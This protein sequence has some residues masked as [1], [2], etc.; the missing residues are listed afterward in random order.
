MPIEVILPTPTGND[1]GRNEPYVIDVRANEEVQNLAVGL[2]FA[3]IVPTE[4]AFFGDPDSDSDFELAY[5]FGSTIEAVSDASPGWSRWRFTLFRRP[6]WLGN[7][8]AT[9]HAVIGVVGPEGPPGP[10]GPQGEQ[11]PP[12]TDG[13]NGTNGS[14]GAAG[15]P[16]APGAPGSQGL[17]GAAG[18]DGDDGEDGEDGQPGFIGFV[19][20]NGTIT[21]AQPQYLNIIDGDGTDAVLDGT[22]KALSFNVDVSDFAGTN[23]E[24][25]GSNNLRIAATAAGAGLIGG[26]ASA[27]AVG[28]GTGITVNA[29]DV[30]I[31]TIA[32]ESFF[33][34]GTA[35]A[36]VPTAIAGST[37][38]GAGLTYT[39]GGILAVGAGTGLTVN[40]NDVQLTTIADDTFMANVSGGAAVA[41]GKTFTS[42]GGDGIDYNA[43]THALDVAVSDFA[44][45][46]L[47][48]DGS[49]NLRIAASAA[50]AG[51]IGGGASALAVG[52]GTFITV[53]A[54]DV[55]LSPV[56]AGRVYGNQIDAVGSAIVELTGAELGENLQFGTIV[57][58]SAA[59]GTQ[60]AYSFPA[61]NNVL[62]VQ[63]TTIRFQGIV[64]RPTGT[65]LWI[66]HTGSGS[67]T[68]E[69]ESVGALSADTLSTGTDS[70]D[71]VLTNRMQALFLYQN[72]RWRLHATSPLVVNENK[73]DLTVTGTRGQTWTINTGGIALTKLAP[74]ADDT[75]LV[76]IAG[77]SASP[78]AVALTAFGGDGIDYNATT[79]AFDVAVADFAGTNLENDGSN[80]LRIAATAAGAGLTGGGASALAVGAGTAIVVNANDVAL[81]VA[82]NITWTGTHTFDDAVMFQKSQTVSPSGVTDI[83]LDADVTHLYLTPS[84]DWSL[85]E[86]GPGSE[87]RILFV[88]QFGAFTGTITSRGAGGVFCPDTVS[89]TITHRH[90]FLLR[91]RIDGWRVIAQTN[92]GVWFEVEESGAGPFNDYA[93]GA[94]TRVHIM[95][96]N[97]AGV[98]NG[99]IGATVAGR[100]L[101]VSHQGTGTTTLTHNNV[102][103][104][105][106]TRFF[107]DT[108]GASV[109]LSDNQS[110]FYIAADVTAGG[111]TTIRW[112]LVSVQPTS[113]SP[114]QMMGL[115]VDAAGVAFPVPLTG[116]EQGEN[117]RIDTRVDDASTSGT[118]SPY[119][120]ATQVNWVRFTALTGL[121]TLNGCDLTEAGKLIVW[122]IEPALA[123]AATFV[124]SNAATT[125]GHRFFCPGGVNITIGAGDIVVTLYTS[126]RH[127]VISVTRQT[128]TYTTTETT[129]GTFAPYTLP[130]LTDTLNVAATSTFHGFTGGVEGRG[131]TVSNGAAVGSGVTISFVQFSS[132]TAGGN[133]EKLILNTFTGTDSTAVTLSPGA[134][135]QLRYFGSR[136][137]TLENVS[138]STVVAVES[139]VAN[140]TAA[141]APMVP[142][143]LASLAGV[144]L[145]YN[146]TTKAIDVRQTH[147]SQTLAVDLT[148][149]NP[150]G[151]I[152][153][154]DVLNIDP[155]AAILLNSLQ[156]PAVDGKQV[157]VTKSAN[158]DSLTIV[159]Q[160]GLGVA[161]N[162]IICIGN[163][164]TPNI[165]LRHAQS[166]VLLQYRTA[167]SR[168]LV[169]EWNPGIASVDNPGLVR[170]GTSLSMSTPDLLNYSGNTANV[171]IS[172]PTGNQGTIDISALT[173]GGTVR[174]LTPV[175]D[176]QIEG[177]TAKTD[178]F[179]FVFWYNGL[180]T[181]T[182]FD[183]DVT[184]TSTNR[185]RFPS[186]V[187]L[188]ADL[189]YGILYYRDSRW[190]WLS[191]MQAPARFLTELAAAPTVA[192]AQAAV[193]AENIAPTQPRWTNDAGN[194]WPLGFAAS[195][196]MTATTTQT[197]NTTP[198][199][200]ASMTVPA[201]ELFQ[202]AVIEFVAHIR[203][204][205]GVI[206]TA[207]DINLQFRVNTTQRYG[208]SV[209]LHTTN[210]FSGHFRIV[211]SLNILAAPGASIDVSVSGQSVESITLAGSSV[212]TGNIFTLSTNASVALDLR[213]SMSAATVGVQFFTEAA[214]IRRVR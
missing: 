106:N 155:G 89:F 55:A 58:E 1:I 118:G 23:L 123:G 122:T 125:T 110:A 25:D 117:L 81:D 199:T 173:C 168:W 188:V 74:Q 4:I 103:S 7:P 135:L 120:V 70:V 101:L 192:A 190:T 206:N 203:C 139:F 80:N 161:A 150:T 93:A 83:V 24:D 62:A 164:T 17:T 52:A 195:A 157:R 205:R 33:V 98:F 160:S 113:I 46:N 109:V 8:T 31:S 159:H 60:T 198:V 22:T 41:T 30:Q 96:S 11:G 191:S 144:G 179:W 212:V 119:S 71:L 108:L 213:A 131:L 170:P 18:E 146:T 181:C 128:G 158:S 34:N 162:D 171:D 50:G 202:G 196:S 152:D 37:V 142:K 6:G 43:T 130:P 65:I 88:E 13:T 29:N 91:Y 97:A 78:T 15:A 38:A 186:N 67:T 132:T 82:A 176:F 209:A 59:S 211:G 68:I 115:Q 148:N 75:V 19:A 141:A 124:H 94:E 105:N 72:G 165:V 208:Q 145:G 147:V 12:G 48:N 111:G 61:P 154:C 177:F 9:V 114:G 2:R 10:A 166:N 27:L 51:L 44:G 138:L 3:R 107:N 99:I 28:A 73:G 207:T 54:N 63:N 86:L 140:A 214:Y 153:L 5:N 26:G 87:G 175:A 45:T 185:I 201:N 36:A 174:A 204:L 149:F 184:A 21:L 194:T 40:V 79:H 169:I 167:L 69:P 102:S 172:S 100:M 121:Y 143:T 85:D 183:E 189:V 163:T 200:L 129:G 47:E 137:H 187:N 32:A 39:T 49:N 134:S 182:L 20:L 77:S 64:A 104:G 84:A 136:W 95:A 76:N 180:S 151:G 42:L 14:D 193:W 16:G 112:L 210:G 53:N 126:N 116:L 178:G 127:R 133:I 197:A 57:V 66:R 35:G 156:A 56:A 92:P 90:A